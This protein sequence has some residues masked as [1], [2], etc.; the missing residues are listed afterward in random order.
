MRLPVTLA[1]ILAA[2]PA[3]AQDITPPRPHCAPAP[4]V[5]RT[6]ADRYREQPAWHGALPEDGFEALLTASS[7]GAT[8]TLMILR[9]DGMACPL[10]AGSSSRMKPRGA[11]I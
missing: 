11:P 4:E 7:D 8:W 6:L 2:T 9:P 10:A 1:A 5:L 3:L